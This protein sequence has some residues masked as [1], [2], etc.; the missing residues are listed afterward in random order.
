MKRAVLYRF[1]RLPVEVL[2]RPES[3]LG[4]DHLEF[5]T[6]AGDVQTVSFVE[7]K[8]ICFVN[9]SGRF[10]LFSANTSFERRPRGPGLWTRFSMR[11]GD[12]LDGVVSQNVLD[13]PPNGFLLT[14]PHAGATRQRVYLPRSALSAV[15]L[16][17]LLGAARSQSRAKQPSQA[18]QLKM[19]DQ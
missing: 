1:D 13:W 10:D 11:D 6:T 2:L 5:L 14:P 9:D 16:L 19:F 18:A 4:A 3:Y 15:E 7:A 12:Q 8:A 17:G